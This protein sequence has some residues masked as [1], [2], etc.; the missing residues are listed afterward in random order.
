MG[1]VVCTW[2]GK[3]PVVKMVT[4]PASIVL[5]FVYERGMMD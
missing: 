1:E 3:I 2:F 5:H 4:P